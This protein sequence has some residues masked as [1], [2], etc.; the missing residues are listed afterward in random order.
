M[1]PSVHRGHSAT[2]LRQID[3]QHA[4]SGGLGYGEIGRD[5]N[6]RPDLIWI[7]AMARRDHYRS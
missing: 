2:V 1:A 6:V 4:N 5:F 3:I 7:N